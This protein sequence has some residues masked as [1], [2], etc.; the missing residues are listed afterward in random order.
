[1]L[2]GMSIKNFRGINKG[3]LDRFGNV[4]ILLGPNNS[5]KS[6]ILEAIYLAST[7]ISKNDLLNRIRIEY[8]ADRRVK[9]KYRLFDSLWYK[10]KTTKPI[11]LILTLDNENSFTFESFKE[12]ETMFTYLNLENRYFIRNSRIWQEYKIVDNVPHFK[13]QNYTIERLSSIFKI[14]KKALKNLI[15]MLSASVMIDPFIINSFNEIEENLWFKIIAERI[16]KKIVKTINSCYNMNIENFSYFKIGPGYSLAALLPT[17]SVR[18]DE[19][20]DGVRMSVAMITIAYLIENSII[21]LEDPETHQHIRALKEIMSTLLKVS[22]SQNNQIFI[23]T[24]SLEL[25]KEI[26]NLSF[27]LDI[28][29]TI[30]GITLDNGNLNVR[31][32]KKEDAKNLLEVGEDIR[33]I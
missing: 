17:H 1:M 26:V 19:I 10:Y 14:S 30:F 32:I 27:R 22:K 29:L 31:T 15:K 18:L 4:N 25:T 21:L 28:D 3:N 23:S 9:R 20:G 7:A 12:N 6:T 24:H 2:T 13:Q 33:I 11:Q 5:G 16:D 8:L